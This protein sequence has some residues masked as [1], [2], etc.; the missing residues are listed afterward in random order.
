MCSLDYDLPTMYVRKAVQA[1]KPHKCSECYRVIAPDETYQ[2]TT[3]VWD[4]SISTF[5]TCHQCNA[6]ADLL[7]AECGGAVHGGIADDIREHVDPGLPWGM[8]AARFAVG[9]RR[10][11]QRFDGN[12]LMTA[13][14]PP[15]G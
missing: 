13:P 9:M 11:W 7:R 2:R 14:E 12:G 15:R 6:A 10:K 4:G 8:T 1:R 3:G 5:L